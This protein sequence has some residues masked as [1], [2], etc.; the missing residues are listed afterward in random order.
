M[1]VRTA[2]QA[3]LLSVAFSVAKAQS[4][5]SVQDRQVAGFERRAGPDPQTW[6]GIAVGADVVGDVFLLKALCERLGEGCLIIAG[7]L[8]HVRVDDF[9]QIEVLERV[10]GSLA[11]LAIQGVRSTQSWITLA[12]ASA[13]AIKASRPPSPSPHD[14]VSR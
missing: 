11:R 3:A 2:A 12:L 5:H 9:R 14:K 8:A 6:R 4:S 10:A 7:K 1:K 13:R